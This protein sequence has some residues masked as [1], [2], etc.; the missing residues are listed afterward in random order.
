MRTGMKLAGAILL[1]VL[2]LTGCNE[3]ILSIGFPDFSTIQFSV[4][5]PPDSE[6]SDGTSLIV[7]HDGADRDT[8]YGFATKDLDSDVNV[9][10][11]R[12]VSELTKK[13]VDYSEIVKSGAYRVTYVNG[14]ESSTL[15]R[16]IVFGLNEDG[17][18]YGTPGE[19]TFTTDR[20]LPV[21]GLSI[22]GSPMHDAVNLNVS[23][24]GLDDET[25]YCFASTDLTTSLETLCQTHV[26]KNPDVADHLQSGTHAFELSGLRHKTTYRAVVVGI[27]DGKVHGKPVSVEFTTPEKEVIPQLNPAWTIVNMGPGEL[28]NKGETKEYLQRISCTATSEDRYFIMVME[29]SEM[30]RY[31]NNDL[32]TFFI[33]ASDYMNTSLENMNQQT[34]TTYKWSD[35]SYT[36]SAKEGYNLKKIGTYNA[37]AIGVTDAGTPSGLYAVSDDFTVQGQPMSPEAQAWLGQ[38]TIGDG[39][40]DYEVTIAPDPYQ[41]ENQYALYG[42]EGE[43]FR[44]VPVV[45]QFDP[46]T[47]RLSILACYL[48]DIT[49]SDGV[50]ATLGFY[51]M[52]GTE[53]LVTSS[54][55]AYIIATADFTNAEKTRALASANTLPVDEQGTT[56]TFTS[57]GYFALSKLDG[58]P[59][60]FNENHPLLP[61]QMTKNSD[62]TTVPFGAFNLPA[63]SAL[64]VYRTR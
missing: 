23:T 50:K 57:L 25:W 37:Y 8:Y 14:L 9:A 30:R 6:T 61:L 64:K 33:A 11:N 15:Y 49:T 39:R 2:L 42:F 26:N 4:K 41:V 54:D 16:Y 58:E 12:E 48:A 18:V 13:N 29:Q 43:Q 46:Q 52:E 17:T 55:Q 63:S 53:F 38:W 22:I 59:I 27:K 56:V 31:Y 7:S 32:A 47:G 60:V 10:V 20:G 35:I 24:T 19:C 62:D 44:D 28:T 1:P 36:A 40:I 21:F 3:A 45:A 51:G 5:V 34:G